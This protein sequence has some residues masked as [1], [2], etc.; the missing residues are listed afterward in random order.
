MKSRLLLCISLGLLVPLAMSVRSTAQAQAR[1]LAS[2]TVTDLGTLGGTYS[3]AY[4]I[5]NSSVVAGGAATPNQTDGVSQTGFLWYDGQSINLGTLGG[6]ACPGCNSEAASGA[7]GE[8]VLISETSNPDPNGEDFCGFGTHRQCLAAIWQNGSLRA[9]PTLQNGQNSQAYWVNNGGEVIGFAENG[10]YDATCSASIAFQIYRFEAV[11]WGS[12]SEP[13]P[14][15]P[16]QGDT[17]SF[18]LGINDRGQAVGVSGLCSNTT[19]PPNYPPGGPHAVLWEKDGSPIDIGSLPG[20]AGNNV[21]NSI[22]NRGEV[23]GTSL[24]SDGT[25]HAFLWKRTKGMQDLGTFPGAFATI[26]PCCNSINARGEV[27]GFSV[28]DTGP[29]AFVW[30]D[31]VLTDLNTVIRAG[32]PWFL[33]AALSINDAGEIVGFG[34]NTNTFEVH[35]FLASPIAMGEG[36]A[37]GPMK[38]PL[39]P[40]SVGEILQRQLHLA[41]VGN[42]SGTR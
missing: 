34:F 25:V 9:L 33:L 7:R 35:A 16:L 28:D 27:A 30:K 41:Q 21:A 31:N 19:L 13:T 5:N 14:L 39:L 42:S 40:Q 3:Y 4:G 18:G 37:R 23:V 32:S 12:G 38:L 20:G 29:R 6:T 10:V 8:A 11:K 15:L 22:N 36:E 24:M 26:A 2:Y 1:R 17:V